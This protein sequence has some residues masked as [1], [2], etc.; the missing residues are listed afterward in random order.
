MSMKRKTQ[1][2]TQTAKRKSARQ[3]ILDDDDVVEIA[4]PPKKSRPAA[5][6]GAAETVAGTMHCIDSSVHANTSH[7]GFG[8][9]ALRSTIVESN[10]MKLLFVQRDAP[11]VVT[12]FL[13]YRD[14]TALR[15]AS[16]QWH[17]WLESTSMCLQLAV[18]NLHPA[19]FPLLAINNWAQRH[20]TALSLSDYDLAE[21]TM[22]V[23]LQTTT[24]FLKHMKCVKRL[25]LSLKTRTSVESINTTQ[26][27]IQAFL[28]A[29]PQLTHLVVRAHTNMVKSFLENIDCV[30]RLHV[31]RLKIPV[32]VEKNIDF[33]RLPMLPLLKEFKFD[34]GYN[35]RCTPRQVQH[36]AA[37]KS[38]HTLEAGGWHTKANVFPNQINATIDSTIGA[39]VRSFA[40]R[41]GKQRLQILDLKHTQITSD[42]WTHIS[43]LTHLKKLTPACWKIS[44]AQEWKQLSNFHALQKLSLN[45]T[46]DAFVVDAIAKSISVLKRLRTLSIFCTD[47]SVLKTWMTVDDKCF[48]QIC[49]APLQHLALRGLCMSSVAMGM[50][51]ASLTSLTIDQC[52]NVNKNVKLQP[53]VYLPSLPLLSVL[54]INEPADAM[55]TR[56][57]SQALND[58]VLTRC[59]CLKRSQ[60]FT[61]DM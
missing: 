45:A 3:Q 30:Q 28:A 15:I 56:E 53:R 58:A 5:N 37:C 27:I 38:L 46:P 17:L 24:A 32:W 18:N 49:R 8:A 42:V 29:V 47:A 55:L 59:P 20:V 48:Q 31:F 51:P 16:K 6:A 60:L 14:I 22:N 36:L 1:Q 23:T 4:P 50:F 44:T 34:A 43:M 41:R 19:T 40:S 25:E 13:T 52:H 21:T 33:S 7:N 54:I 35:Y 61:N 39:L 9:D 12:R 2:H 57:V 26:H 10:K 11:L